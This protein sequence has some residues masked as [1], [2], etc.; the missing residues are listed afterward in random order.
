MDNFYNSPCLAQ[1]LKTVQNTKTE[2]KK[3]TEECERHKTQRSKI[4]A[5][6]CSPVSVTKLSDKELLLW[7]WHHSHS[8]RTVTIRGKETVKPISV[9]DYN[10]CI[11]GVDL[12]DQLLHSYLIERKRMIK[13]YMKLFRRLLNA[14]IIYRYNTC[15]RMDQLSFRIRLA[16]GLWS[17]LTC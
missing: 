7:C 3:C 11:G 16:E 13:W 4:I 14:F 8:T 10:H 1:T 2:L 17:M 5:Q 15:K 6:H 12:K 9:L